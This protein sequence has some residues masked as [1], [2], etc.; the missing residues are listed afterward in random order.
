[1]DPIRVGVIG[2]GYLGEH[3]ARIYS[4]MAGVKLTGVVDP[5]EERARKIG[6]KVGC[7]FFTKHGEILG[8]VDAVS[9]AAPTSFHHD[10]SLDCLKN[11][12]DV[13]LEK[14]MTVTLEEADRLVQEAEQNKRIFQIGHL[15]R[16]NGAIR[17]LKEV[18]KDPRFVESHR[19]GP[20][21]NRGTDVDVIL[22]LMIHD[23]D[24]LLSVVQSKVSEIR[25]VGTPVI[26][27]NVD[28][29]NARIEFEGGCVA[30]VTASRV[31]LK[32]ERKIRI[33]QPNAYI[34]LDYQLQELMVYRRVMDPE[35]GPQIR[36][37]KIETAKDEPLRVELEAFIH[38]VRSREHPVVSGRD[39]REA[40]KVA[41]KIISLMRGS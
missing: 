7:P 11:N 33:F 27:S 35:K 5:D 22:D 20:F 18:V 23:I 9:I 14:P 12:I 24:I 1:M 38:S 28:I 13:L 15:E 39:G 30:N 16:F 17:K 36:M 21:V 26:S 3:H 40:L 29:A 2:V 6:K 10:L 8:S 4:E 41:L 25:A 37:E 19:I 32:K 34:S 31:S